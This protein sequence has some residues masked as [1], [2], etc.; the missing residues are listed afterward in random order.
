MEGHVMPIGDY[1]IHF[2]ENWNIPTKTSSAIGL[3][4]VENP[5]YV[6]K[7]DDAKI[8][9]S[10]GN[11]VNVFCICNRVECLFCLYIFVLFLFLVILYFQQ[12]ITVLTTE[13]LCKFAR[14]EFARHSLT[15]I[16]QTRQGPKI[17]KSLLFCFQKIIIGAIQC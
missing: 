10:C 14:C 13:A 8:F 11:W 6:R 16:L 4:L 1:S 15:K 3:H 7:Y 5:E 12:M 17:N 2:W 9:Y